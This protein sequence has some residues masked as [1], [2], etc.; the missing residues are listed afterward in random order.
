MTLRDFIYID[1][2]RMYSLYSQLFEGVAE[3][4][5]RS[6]SYSTEEQRAEKKLEETIIDA[7]VKTQNVV[8]FDHIYNTLEEK[9]L[10]HILVIGEKT[11]KDD[12]NPTSIIKVTGYV[13]IEDYEH[14]SYLMA[15]FNDIGL[16]L[17]TM[18][19]KTKS[20]DG[21]TPSNNSVEQYAKAQ[22]LTMDKKYAA[23][24]VKFIENLHGNTMEILIETDNDS[25]NLGFRA[26]L[27]QEHLRFSS[28]TLRA[29]YGYKPCMK[30]TMVG[31]VT[32]IS[33]YN[34]SYQEKCKSRFSEMFKRLDDV[35]RSFSKANDVLYDFV[36]I[37]PIAV[38]I[39]HDSQPLKEAESDI[40]TN[41]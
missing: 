12:I 36:R 13:I 17:A 27:D 35:D 3:S 34:N 28:N 5:V 15:N 6:V 31:E 22:G 41:I 23:S 9:M 40:D 37:A 4:M 38:Y 8:L 1:K 24:I 21:K 14:L 11:V 29:L 2:N 30:W 18:Q 10:Q 20:E 16:A 7:S 39:E 25:L 19:I 32:D 26:L 33:Y